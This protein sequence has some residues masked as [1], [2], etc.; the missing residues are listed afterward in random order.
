[1]RSVTVR[2]EDLRTMILNLGFVGENEHRQIRFDS[3]KMFAE[4]PTA[5]AAMTVQPPEGDAYPA[6]IERDGDFV[7]WTVSDSDL[8][9]DGSG[10]LQLAFTVDEVVARTY[11]GKTK[12][13]RS[14]I[15]TG[16]IPSGLDDFLVRASAALTA[17]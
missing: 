2:L 4:Y 9:S 11:V 7:I 3:S 6:V 1:M 5:S 10:E 8:I 13:N 17:R 14:I 12:I 15:P 16:E